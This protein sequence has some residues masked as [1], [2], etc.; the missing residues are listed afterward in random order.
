M[1]NFEALRNI[2]STPK[3][4]L[5]TTHQN[6]DGDAMGSSLGLARYLKK[7]GHQVTVITP[8]NYPDFLKWLPGN[9]EVLIYPYNFSQSKTVAH[10]AEV[11][12]CLDFNALGRI[13]EL[14]EQVKHSSAVKVM[15]DH[16]Q[17]PED[18]AAYQLWDVTASSTAELIYDFIKLMGDPELI[19]REI[20]DCLYTGLLTDT[21][22]FQHPNTTPKVMRVAAE[23][24][25]QGVDSSTIYHTVFNSFT[26]QRLRLFGYSITEKLKVFPD[27]HAATISLSREE[28]QRFNVK[29]GDTEGIVNY[30]LK[31]VG[32][33]LSILIIDRTEMI[34]LSFRSIGKFDVNTFARKHF[35]G[36]GHMNASGGTSTDTLANTIK[37]LEEILPLYKADLDY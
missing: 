14:G 25:E 36:G 15:I 1:E 10:E 16:H 6:P 12:F 13:N 17:Q 3:K 31:V 18:F 28:I 4:V 27:L 19:D 33:H 20:A 26:E 30:P 9:S 2:L 7:K 34:K 11:I 35:N 22:G 8:T 32:I 37:K 23:M 21:G 24:L 5:I 29:S